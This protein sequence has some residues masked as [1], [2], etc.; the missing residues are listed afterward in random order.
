MGST[1]AV[2]VS[3]CDVIGSVSDVA[4]ST[5]DVIG[6]TAS[7]LLETCEGPR[8]WPRSYV[9]KSVLTPYFAMADDAQGLALELAG[10]REAQDPLP[11]RGP[12]LIH[13]AGRR[14]LRVMLAVGESGESSGRMWGTGQGGEKRGRGAMGVVRTLAVVGTGGPGAYRRVKAEAARMRGAHPLGHHEDESDGQL[15]GALRVDAR[16]DAQLP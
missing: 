11:E 15:S 16:C 3:V 7:A 1:S 14:T 12:R 8:W 13:L 10:D 9:R 5:I 4:D 2:V 6:S